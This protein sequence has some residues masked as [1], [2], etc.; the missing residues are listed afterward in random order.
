VVSAQGRRQ[1]NLVLILAR[2]FASNLAT[3]MALTDARGALVFYNEPAEILLG[4]TFAETGELPAARLGELF[5]IARL[6]GSPMAR[7]EMPGGIAL[8]ERREA[9]VAL[10]ITGLDGV[11]RTVEATAFPL[12]DRDDRPVGAVTLFWEE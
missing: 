8:F 5:D 12:L 10:R 6:D 11:E 1:K 3:P 2:E 4:R 7:E 9:H